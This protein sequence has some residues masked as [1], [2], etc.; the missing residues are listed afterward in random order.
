MMMMIINDDALNVIE[1]RLALLKYNG[2]STS[3]NWK[4]TIESKV[5]W[6]NNGCQL[7]ICPL[8]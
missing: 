4:L 3:T 7:A 6:R 2:T 8:G 5:Y 1:N